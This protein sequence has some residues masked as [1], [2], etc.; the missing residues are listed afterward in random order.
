MHNL[1]ANW[2]CWSLAKGVFELPY[3]KVNFYG[4]GHVVS[5]ERCQRLSDFYAILQFA[6]CLH[7]SPVV[8][9]AADWNF[10]AFGLFDLEPNIFEVTLLIYKD[11]AHSPLAHPSRNWAAGL[12][13]CTQSS[14]EQCGL[15]QSLSKPRLLYWDGAWCFFSPLFCSSNCFTFSLN[16][17][18]CAEWYL[19]K[20]TLPTGTVHKALLIVL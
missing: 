3:W 16:T 14:M 6:G 20:T 10:M 17:Q 18:L 19:D 7:C 12:G 11:C 15:W 13:S 9:W 4:C 8:S 1:G 2:V 5:W